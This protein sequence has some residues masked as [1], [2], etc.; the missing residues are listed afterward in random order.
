MPRRS[1]SQSSFYD[2]EVVQPDCLEPGTVPWLLARFR[3]ML[4]PEWLFK[5]WRGEGRRG[6]DA[7]PAVSLIALLFLRWSEEG[8]PMDRDRPRNAERC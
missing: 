5:G 3:S 2:P 1:L 6:R 8:P 4:F 7:W